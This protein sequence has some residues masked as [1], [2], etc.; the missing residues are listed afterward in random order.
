M[1]VI[2]SFNHLVPQ[3]PANGENTNWQ[4]SITWSPHWHFDEKRQL[5]NPRG[6]AIRLLGVRM[7]NTNHHHNFSRLQTLRFALEIQ[8]SQS[9]LHLVPT[10][11][12]LHLPRRYHPKQTRKTPLSQ[13]LHRRNINK[14][15]LHETKINLKRRLHHRHHNRKSRRLRRWI[16]VW[17]HPQNEH[18]RLLQQPRGNQRSPPSGLIVHQRLEKLPTKEK[19]LTLHGR[20][21]KLHSPTQL[22]LPLYQ[23]S[24]LCHILIWSRL[25]NARR[26]QLF[27]K[28]GRRRNQ[29]IKIHLQNTLRYLQVRQVQRAKRYEQILRLLRNHIRKTLWNLQISTQSL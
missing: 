11:P 10:Q 27:Q 15:R 1:L 22:L 26:P 17:L 6:I 25:W 14:G 2:R 5:N 20:V 7:Q 23:K 16:R 9:P 19:L 13:N 21:K 12:Y 29:L 18:L 8:P 4:P 3:R 28:L 24:H